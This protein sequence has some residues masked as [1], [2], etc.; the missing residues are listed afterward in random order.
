M[1]DQ[2]NTSDTKALADTIKDLHTPQI[3]T[4]TDPSSSGMGAIPF[5][6]VPKGMAAQSLKP[7]FDEYRYIPE[8]KTGTAKVQDLDSFGLHVNRYKTPS[9]IIFCK[10]T[11]AAPKNQPRTYADAV[12]ALAHASDLWTMPTLTA[13]L[14]YHEQNGKDGGPGTPQWGQHRTAYTF[15]LSPQFLAWTTFNAVPLGQSDLAQFFE[16]RALDVAP[17][18]TF[19]ADDPYAQNADFAALL[20]R[21]TQLLKG[22]WASPMDVMDMSRTMRIHESSTVE[23]S[24]RL[25]SG[26]QNIVYQTEHTDGQGQKFVPKDLFLIDI[27]IFLDGTPYTLPVRLRY[28]IDRNKVVWTYEIFRL[29]L[30]IN[31]A[32]NA[33]CDTVRG[34]TD[35][36]VISGHPEMPGKL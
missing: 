3:I 12:A 33:A 24:A 34:L 18:P 1:S 29:D 32:L 11:W 14:D 15:P 20:Q 13:V 25:S 19:T 2:T 5:A 17:P 21:T 16:E 36:P 22:S 28:R 6:V 27:P 35:L 10:R 9:S 7:Y 8:R 26:Q 30:C 31:H 4:V 23:N